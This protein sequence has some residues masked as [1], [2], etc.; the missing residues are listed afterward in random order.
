MTTPV[1]GETQ[2]HIFSCITAAQTLLSCESQSGYVLVYVPSDMPGFNSIQK[3]KKRQ[4]LFPGSSCHYC[5]SPAQNRFEEESICQA[6]GLLHVCVF[7]SF[8][9][10]G[11]LELAAFI[12]FSAPATVAK[13]N[14][15]GAFKWI[16]KLCI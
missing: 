15:P 9:E 1:Y 5:L 10:K 13:S 2:K 8:D 4:L 3:G 6:A 16:A 7:C 12:L 14:N 11:G